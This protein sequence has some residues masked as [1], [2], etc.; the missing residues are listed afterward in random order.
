MK[1]IF[2]KLIGQIYKANGI[3]NGMSDYDCGYSDA[4]TFCEDVIDT[5]ETE[6]NTLIQQKDESLK[7]ADKYLNELII[8]LADK[9]TENSNYKYK[10]KQLSDELAMYK[11][12]AS[13]FNIALSCIN[14]S[15]D[16][17][18]MHEIALKALIDNTDTE[19]DK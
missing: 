10:N 17:K 18:E 3:N 13:K 6:L 1:D 5:A 4:L 19:G 8:K 14:E 15:S 12:E 2:Q 16:Y 9:V 7:E 11:Q